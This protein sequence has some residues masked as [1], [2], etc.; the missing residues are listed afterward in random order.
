MILRYR[1]QLMVKHS[2]AEVPIDA[3]AGQVGYR[4]PEFQ[5]FGYTTNRAA[6][7]QPPRTRPIKLLDWAAPFTR[8][9]GGGASGYTC[10]GFDEKYR[11]L[12]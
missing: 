4:K 10:Q 3:L 12:G 5:K 8:S 11:I 7:S 6:T 9:S 2:T 1:A